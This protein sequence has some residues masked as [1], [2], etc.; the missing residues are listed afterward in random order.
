MALLGHEFM[1]FGHIIFFVDFGDCML[2][3]LQQAM[4]QVDQYQNRNK[5]ELILLV[6]LFTQYKTDTNGCAKAIGFA[7]LTGML[8]L[9]MW[10]SLHT[11]TRIHTSHINVTFKAPPETSHGTLQTPTVGM[12]ASDQTIL[13]NLVR[14]QFRYNKNSFQQVYDTVQSLPVIAIDMGCLLWHKDLIYDV[15]YLFDILE[16][17]CFYRQC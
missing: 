15:L 1:C 10:G 8:N 12:N 3:H 17:G 9:Y 5:T 6:H 4:G 16:R 13:V 7:N 14:V 2:L 11:L